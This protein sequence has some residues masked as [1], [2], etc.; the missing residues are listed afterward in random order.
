V[1]ECARTNPH[2]H[3]ADLAWSDFIAALQAIFETCS[4]QPTQR[5]EQLNQLVK[6]RYP[7]LLSTPQ[8]QQ[9]LV[10]CPHQH[11]LST[12]SWAQTL[13]QDSAC[14]IG[15]IAV[16]RGQA[17][18]LHDHTGSSGLSLVLSGRARIRYARRMGVNPISGMTQIKLADT[19]ECSVQQVSGFDQQHNLHS[20]EAISAR[21]QLLVVHLPPINREKQAF[22][23]PLEDKP[24]CSGQQIRTKRI[25]IYYNLGH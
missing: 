25:R 17:M 13:Y 16:Y 24:W 4:D 18:P 8:L 12:P 21:A 22:Y 5:D 3:Q 9:A 2:K 1:A 6:Q 11:A 19:Q 10:M 20:I 23:F 15:L 14:H 7:S